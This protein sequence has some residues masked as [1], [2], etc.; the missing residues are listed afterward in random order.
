MNKLNK[1][2]ATG[3]DWISA[4]LIRECA[5]FICVPVCD[6][7]NQSTRQGKPPEDWI[8]AGVTPFF[9]QGDR[10]DVNNYRLLLVIRVVV[11]VLERKIYEPLYAYLQD[12]DIEDL[13]NVHT[14]LKAIKA[15]KH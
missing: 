5:D 15:V 3:L 11:K 7:F 14:W 12:H 9:K 13:L 6:I 10:D 8:S 4:R 2:K 1:S